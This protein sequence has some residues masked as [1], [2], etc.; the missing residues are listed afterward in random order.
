MLRNSPESGHLAT[1]FREQAEGSCYR[2]VQ[3]EFYLEPPTPPTVSEASA[4][5][6]STLIGSDPAAPIA[7]V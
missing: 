6:G 5:V 1:C 4:S 2:L 3:T 7:L